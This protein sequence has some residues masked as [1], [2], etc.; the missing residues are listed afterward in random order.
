LASTDRG[1]L[2]KL[3][4]AAMRPTYIYSRKVR[5]EYLLLVEAAII[6]DDDEPFDAP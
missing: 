5:A 4:S 2:G 1:P 6:C 3:S